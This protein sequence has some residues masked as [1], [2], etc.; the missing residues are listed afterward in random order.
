MD[1]K[2]KVLIIGD[3]PNLSTSIGIFLLKEGFDVGLFA[4]SYET[5]VALLT[6]S[7]PNLVLIER[8]MNGNETETNK[9]VTFIDTKYRLPIVFITQYENLRYSFI[10]SLNHLYIPHP[11]FDSHFLR[12]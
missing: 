5:A 11:E 4:N 6:N 8:Y 1:K 9:I 2:H 10:N 3:N 12:I 7:L